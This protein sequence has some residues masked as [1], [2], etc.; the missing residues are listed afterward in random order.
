MS[1]IFSAY[2]I[3]CFIVFLFIIQIDDRQYS[4]F[5]VNCSPIDPQIDPLTYRDNRIDCA[6][7][8]IKPYYH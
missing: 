3:I 6:L 7:T 4:V 5:T 2:Y 8:Y 1:A